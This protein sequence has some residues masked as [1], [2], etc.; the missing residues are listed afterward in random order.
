ME[1]QELDI[2]YVMST[3][4]KWLLLIVFFLLLGITLAIFYNY[5]APTIYESKTSLYAKPTV[6]ESEADYTDIVT[7]QKM[8]KTYMQIIKSRKVVDQV[9]EKLDLEYKYSELMKQVSIGNV[10]DTTIITITVDNEKAYLAKKIANAMAKT[11]ISEISDTMDINNI[12]IID[13]AIAGSEPVSP[14]PLLNMCIGI[15]GGLT[16]GLTLAFLFE[17]M[18][19]KIKNHEDIKK[20]LKIKTLGV[21][22]HNSIDNEIKSNKKKEYV[23]PNDMSLKIISSPTSVVSESIKM[24][25]TNLNFLDL[26]LINVTSTLPSEGKSEAICNLAVSFAMLDKKVLVVDCDLR[27]PKIH[28]NFGLTRKTGIADV[29]LSKDIDNYSKHVQTFTTP[30]NKVSID[31]L[32]AGS[33]ISNPSELINNKTFENLLNR[34]KDD[35][36]LILVDCPPISSLTDGVLVSKLCDGTVYVI[37]SDRID[38][39]V[40]GS[41]IEELQNNKVFI[42][43]AI[44]TKVNIKRQKQLYGYKYD[45]YYSNY[46]K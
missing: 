27:K 17:S 38:Y 39:K 10:D 21:V 23:N 19:N 1:R 11:F 4:G 22:P 31:L 8:I 24:I 6:E 44:L 5:G 7:N 46:D 28:K 33:R 16:I 2:N 37:E 45:Y 32:T 13:E 18:D 36:D 42:L 9:I 34:L 35:Y 26:K 25:R 29:I 14:R 3:I 20:Y 43:G 30:D 41:C 12:T 15:L 40:I